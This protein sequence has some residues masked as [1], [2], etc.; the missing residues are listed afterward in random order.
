VISCFSAILGGMRNPQ[1]RFGASFLGSIFFLLGVDLNATTTFSELEADVYLSCGGS[2]MCL[3]GDLSM[4]DF[5]G[6]GFEDLLYPDRSSG[7]LYVSNNV[8][9][10][11]SFASG[12]FGPSISDNK[13]WGYG[14]AVSTR[15]IGLGEISGDGKTD[16]FWYS[17]YP[18]ITIKVTLGRS[19]PL[20]LISPPANIDFVKW[21][22]DYLQNPSRSNSGDV[23]GDGIKDAIFYFYPGNAYVVFGSTSFNTLTSTISLSDPTHVMSILGGGRG[24]VA[25]GDLDGD[26][27]DDILI[28]DEKSCFWATHPARGRLCDSRKHKSSFCM[29]LSDNAP[30][31]GR[32]MG[33]AWKL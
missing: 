20:P 28:G 17:T 11:N 29:E 25:L 6:D 5:D 16:S 21:G 9:F 14:I 33:R 27:Y 30:P 13:D 19:N 3:T 24:Q 8:V 31:I 10:G 7:G 22:D 26:G 4:G 18:P 15:N 23:N 32:S 12:E 1:I 2:Y